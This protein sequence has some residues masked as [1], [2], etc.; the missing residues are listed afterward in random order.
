VVA[1]VSG[2]ANHD[3]GGWE[4][5]GGPAQI[6]IDPQRGGES[7]FSQDSGHVLKVE[8]SAD[9]SISLMQE[10]DDLEPFR[11]QPVVF[12]FTGIE[13]HGVARVTVELDYGTSVE[14][15][16]SIV[17]TAMGD[18]RR[19]HLSSL[20]PIE[21]TALKVRLTVSGRSGVSVGLG[22]ATLVIGSGLIP[23]V[24]NPMDRMIPS[25]TII[26]YDGATCPVG[27]VQAHGGEDAFMLVQPS[28][29]HSVDGQLNDQFGSNEHNHTGGGTVDGLL[30]DDG[31]PVTHLVK[32]DAHQQPMYVNIDPDPG[33]V[34]EVGGS[35]GT[36]YSGPVYRGINPAIAPSV[37]DNGKTVAL[38]PVYHDHN[39]NY[40]GET[41]PPYRTWLT[42]EKV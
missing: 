37:F 1:V 26:L 7:L 41:V 19:T 36:V 25:G 2:T 34:T 24:D 17:S 40:R 35:I 32:E 33:V 31:V 38:L 10:M 9:G 15:L 8:L 16:G 42:C 11:G 20:V 12:S 3:I 4:I 30:T 14:P 27:Y 29:P 5:T 18:Y 21:I 22:G 6:E 23:Y 28:N 39:V 13:F